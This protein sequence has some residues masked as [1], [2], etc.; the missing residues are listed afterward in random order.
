MT[1]DKLKRQVAIELLKEAR[2]IIKE[3]R[4]P[5]H[6][7]FAASTYRSGEWR[8]MGCTRCRAEEKADV[9]LQKLKGETANE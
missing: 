1:V 3:L 9:F 8:H 7:A 2:T 5:G 4:N 6:H